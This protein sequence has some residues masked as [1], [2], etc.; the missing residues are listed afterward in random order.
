MAGEDAIRLRS[1]FLLDLGDELSLE[2]L[3]EVVRTA[4]GWKLQLTGCV[5]VAR[6]HG[7]QIARA[8]SVR[9]ADHDQIRD[10]TIPGKE[11]DGGGGVAH[12]SVTVGH[13]EH[14]ITYLVRFVSHRSANQDNPVFA[15]NG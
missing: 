14:R 9:D 1:I 15:E 6:L 10:A 5:L 13:V 12:V 3:Q 2:E 11:L 8:I 4:A 7:R